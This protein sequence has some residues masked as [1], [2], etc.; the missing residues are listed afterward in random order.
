MVTMTTPVARTLSGFNEELDKARK[1]VA[2][3]MAM[4]QENPRDPEKR[5]RLAYRQ[6]HLASLTA[7]PS[8]MQAV[9][10]TIA[11]AIAD[12]GFKEDLCLLKANVDARHHRVTEA[13]HI[14]QSCPRL[15][16]RPAA[17]AMLA[18]L[19]FQEG[20]YA[21]AA[22]QIQGLIAENRSWDNLARLAHF[23]G[24]FGEH[25]TADKLYAEAEDEL[26]AK[27]MRSYAWIELQ[28][29][30]LAI[31]RGRL[32]KAREHYERAAAAYPGH[33][34]TDEH[35]AE[36]LAAEGKFDKAVSLLKS[37]ID[38]APKPE[39]KHELGELLKFAGRDRESQGWFEEAL[40]AYLQSAASGGVHYY[41]HLTDFYAEAMPNPAEA[42]RWAKKDLA[43]RSNFSTQTAMALAL[44][45]DGQIDEGLRYIKLA[46]SSGV[47]DGGIFRVASGL[48][49]AAGDASEADRYAAAAEAFNPHGDGFHM[50]H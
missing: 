42:V 33:W 20:R 48:L 37:V 22:T 45:L 35:M 13:R 1:D 23:K 44:H 46:L 11:Q 26:T 27:E 47:I 38:R 29:G 7:S 39:L 43:L 19:D 18:D 8:D 14:L 34:H 41:H 25:P 31:T 10:Q 4:S 32:E 50:H 30:V 2:A 49:N 36:L 40:A 15:A 17:R 28:R 16:Q 21:E 9:E 5:V 3:L 24:K 6:F 12:F